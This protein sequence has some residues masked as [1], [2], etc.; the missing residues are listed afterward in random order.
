LSNRLQIQRDSEKW[1]GIAEQKIEA[2][3]FIKGLPRSGTTLL[4]N[5]LAQDDREFY[6]PA[7]S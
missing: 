2:P 6:A 1:P 3:L 7:T 4:H 5:L